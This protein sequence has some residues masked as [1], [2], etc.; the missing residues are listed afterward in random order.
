MKKALLA[1]I[2][3]VSMGAA[4]IETASAAPPSRYEQNQRNDRNDRND[5]NQ[6]KRGSYEVNG[7]RYER[8]N[9]PSWKAPRGYHQQNWQRGQR[10]PVEYRKVVVRDYRTAHLNSPPRG[11]EYVRVGNDVVLTAIATGVISAVIAN[12]FFN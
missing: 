6:F 10:L 12:A 3:V 9:G 4:S 7:H 8:I 11:Y 2:A 1:A 5:H